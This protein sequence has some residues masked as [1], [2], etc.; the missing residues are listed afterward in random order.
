MRCLLLP[1]LSLLLLAT[2]SRSGERQAD[3]TRVYRVRQRTTLD[4]VRGAGSVR[5]W[6]SIPDD[7]RNQDILD[8]VVVSAPGTWRVVRDVERGQRFL[9]VEV[10]RTKTA[11]L[12]VV[13]EFTLRRRPVRF[14]LDP[15]RVGS[16][17]DAH[18]RFFAEELRRD[19]PHMQVTSEL[20]ALADR[21]CGNE[22]NVARQARLLLDHVAD[23]ADHYSKD[24]SKPTCGIGDAGSCLSHGG[25]CCTDLHSLFIALARARGIPARLQMGYRL[26]EKN[27][28]KEV[29][30]GYRCWVEYFVPGYG[31][32]PAD[33]V[34]ADAPG[35]RG[36][37][38]W[39]T[40][41]TERRLWLNRGRDFV[42]RP[43]ASGPVSTM[44]IG[45]AEIDGVPARTLPEQDKKAQLSRRVRFVELADVAAGRQ[46]R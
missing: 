14:R 43:H 40:G 37:A 42:L 12:E 5:W 21:V 46:G 30:P 10:G 26:L 22:T 38:R 41:L 15:K 19:A 18:R 27:A 1:L 33:I 32:I 24:P 20:S 7:C 36:R 23:T 44:S 3:R 45:Y 31:W 9:Y 29:D 6:I 8:F 28:G 34:E 39:F 35:G 17:T 2:G 11:S 16:L 4:Q 13:V 25:G